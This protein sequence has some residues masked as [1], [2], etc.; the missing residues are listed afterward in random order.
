MKDD[1]DGAAA[2]SAVH[3]QQFAT[4]IGLKIQVEKSHSPNARP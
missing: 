3:Y 1:I 4:A 2:R